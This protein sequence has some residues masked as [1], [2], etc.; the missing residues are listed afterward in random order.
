MDPLFGGFVEAED[1]VF[2][3]VTHLIPRQLDRIIIDKLA[4]RIRHLRRLLT[5]YHHHASVIDR[6]GQFTLT[7]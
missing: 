7:I 1:L 2:G 3:L 5:R 6:G 4:K